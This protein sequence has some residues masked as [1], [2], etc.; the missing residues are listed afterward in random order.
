MVLIVIYFF[1]WIQEIVF[2]INTTTI[3]LKTEFSK[4]GNDDKISCFQNNCV[5]IYSNAVLIT[6]SYNMFLW[7]NGSE[8]NDYCSSMCSCFLWNQVNW[9]DLASDTLY[10]SQNRKE[11]FTK[12]KALSYM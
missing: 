8:A 4:G 3:H 11:D 7:S 1:I 9:T 10:K 5:G 6:L 12:S 2:K